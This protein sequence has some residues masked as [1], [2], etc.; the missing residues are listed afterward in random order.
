MSFTDEGW[1][2]YSANTVGLKESQP[3]VLFFFF[4]FEVQGFPLGALCVLGRH[5][6]AELHTQ[7]PNPPPGSKMLG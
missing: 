2:H 4:F 3:R 5:C 6:A 1:G 7:S